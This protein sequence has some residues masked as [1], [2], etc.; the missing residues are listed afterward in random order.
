LFFNPWICKFIWVEF[1]KCVLMSEYYVKIYR[2]FIWLFDCEASF[3]ALL[4]ISF[5]SFWNFFFHEIVLNG[6]KIILFSWLIGFF[7]IIVKCMFHKSLD[8]SQNICTVFNFDFCNFCN[9]IL[10]KIVH[11]N[12]K[13]KSEVDIKNNRK[14]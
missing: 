14:T 6:L 7:L 4:V 5:L 13:L 3:D 8:D 10:L 9:Y 1:V 11:N 2:S 12:I